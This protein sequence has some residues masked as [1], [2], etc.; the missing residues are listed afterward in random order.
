MSLSFHVGPRDFQ[1]C[2]LVA[3]AFAHGDISTLGGLSLFLCRHIPECKPMP[4]AEDSSHSPPPVLQC[5]HSAPF[6][7]RCP[8]RSESVVPSFFAG[9]DTWSLILS[10]L[11][12]SALAA[13]QFLCCG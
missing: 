8:L 11:T 2:G 5:L 10:T 6:Y 9:L 3:G 7:P 12:K 1:L 13:V 4:R